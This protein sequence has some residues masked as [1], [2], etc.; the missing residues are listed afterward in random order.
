LI[1]LIVGL[2]G[3]I[4]GLIGLIV[5]LIGLIVSLIDRIVDVNC[6]IIRAE[7]VVSFTMMGAVVFVRMFYVS[8][9]I[10][11]NQVFPRQAADSHVAV[12]SR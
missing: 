3:L 11:M 8:L 6:R 2:I 4:V 9:V 1:G 7:R 12:I 10:C 5:G